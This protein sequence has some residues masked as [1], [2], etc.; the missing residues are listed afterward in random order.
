MVTQ[1]LAF[2]TPRPAAPC[3]R[4]GSHGRKCGGSMLRSDDGQRMY[5]SVCRL[6]LSHELVARLEKEMSHKRVKIAPEP[7]E[8]PWLESFESV[9]KKDVVQA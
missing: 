4:R 2:P 7:S 8:Q 1:L 5:C 9:P 6:A 3:P